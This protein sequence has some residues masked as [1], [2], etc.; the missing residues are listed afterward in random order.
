MAGCIQI[1]ENTTSTSLLGMHGYLAAV[2]NSTL[3]NIDHQPD[4]VRP[5][6]LLLAQVAVTQPQLTTLSEKALKGSL[7][8]ATSAG[9]QRRRGCGLMQTKGPGVPVMRSGWDFSPSPVLH[10][11]LRRQDSNC[12]QLQVCVP[13]CRFCLPFAASKGR[14]SPLLVGRE[15][16]HAAALLQ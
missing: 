13:M 9:P 5:V 14:P 15:C 10:A 16:P 4:T 2:V 3:R 7:T 12:F 1:L 11:L 6:L 8:E